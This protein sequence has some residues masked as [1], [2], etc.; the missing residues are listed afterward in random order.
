LAVRIL[1]AFDAEVQRKVE[2]YAT[3]AREE[4]L[5]IKGVKIKKL[6]WEAYY[7]QMEKR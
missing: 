2:E 7:E 1:G 5:D 4:N 6:G 3:S